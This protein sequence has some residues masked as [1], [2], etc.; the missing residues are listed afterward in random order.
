M[1]VVFFPKAEH[2]HGFFGSDSPD[3]GIF[4]ILILDMI[5]F[6]LHERTEV[7]PVI[8]HGNYLV[9]GL[10]HE[11]EDSWLSALFCKIDV[12]RC[13]ALGML[14]HRQIVFPAQCIGDLPHPVKCPFVAVEL[15]AVLV[16]DRVDD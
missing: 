10:P 3:G 8:G 12:P 14:N 7:K 15:L 9:D 1:R 4:P 13:F 6:T 2:P 11:I 16:A 5:A